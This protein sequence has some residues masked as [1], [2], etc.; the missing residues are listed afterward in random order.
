MRDCGVAPV[1]L[2]VAESFQICHQIRASCNNSESLPARLFAAIFQHT[3]MH[4]G[5]LAHLWNSSL[6]VRYSNCRRRQLDRVFGQG[7]A[8]KVYSGTRSLAWRA[9]TRT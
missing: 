3:E 8:D 4:S 9:G 6:D 1:L 2:Q 5:T 7:S